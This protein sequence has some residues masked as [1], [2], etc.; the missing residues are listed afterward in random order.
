MIQL[1]KGGVSV[2]GIAVASEV[3]GAGTALA[4]LILIYI[5]VLVSSYGSYQPQEQKAVRGKF[6]ARAW[7]AF[8]GFSLAILSAVLGVLGKWLGSPCTG[9]ASVIVLL[10]AF[11]WTVFGTVQ[12]IREIS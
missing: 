5:G 4:G 11:G 2:N 7:L 6:Q 9:N 3:V 8:V 10:V 1:A 12:T